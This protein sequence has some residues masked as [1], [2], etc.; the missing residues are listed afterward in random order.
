MLSSW[1]KGIEL[2]KAPYFV[3]LNVDDAWYSDML[4]SAMEVLKTH[5]DVGLFF[6]GISI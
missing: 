2:C 5:P 1:N 6:L 4:E 3:K